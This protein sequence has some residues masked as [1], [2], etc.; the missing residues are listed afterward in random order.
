M[1]IDLDE[2]ILKRHQFENGEAHKR[3]LEREAT[4]ESMSMKSN[5]A[6]AIIYGMFNKEIK[7]KVQ[8]H[9]LCAGVKKIVFKL[10]QRCVFFEPSD[11]ITVSMNRDEKK[12]LKSLG[13]MVMPEGARENDFVTASTKFNNDNSF[14]GL[15]L[16]NVDELRNLAANSPLKFTL[17]RGYQANPQSHYYGHARTLY[18]KIKPSEIKKRLKG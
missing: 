1:S 18:C 4:L 17:H 3:K 16:V 9:G 15:M 14:T 6:A 10:E 12:F 2:L 5:A 11:V 8:K 7:E 13:W